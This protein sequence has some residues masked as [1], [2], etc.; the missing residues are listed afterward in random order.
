MIDDFLLVNHEL[1]FPEIYIL[2]TLVDGGLPY[3]DL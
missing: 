1:S 2:F 3:D